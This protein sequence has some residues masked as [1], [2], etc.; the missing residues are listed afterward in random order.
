MARSQ[1][2]DLWFFL[3][4]LGLWGLGELGQALHVGEWLDSLPFA[5][6]VTAKI[7]FILA[8]LVAPFAAFVVYL[9]RRQKAQ[10]P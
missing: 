1:L 3:V 5:Y 4:V 7:A 2:T 10:G 6:Q 8:M 9:G